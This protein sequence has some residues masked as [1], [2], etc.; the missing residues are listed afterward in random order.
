M[1]KKIIANIF[2]TKVDAI[3]LS[4]FRMAYILVLF[5]E[6]FQ[7]FKFRNIVYDKI[8]FV[9]S[10][11]LYVGFIFLIW[12]V[13]LFLLFIGLFTRTAALIN[14]IFSMIIFS[15]AH[16]FEYHVFYAYVGINLLL[17]FMPIS[18]V[19]S[20]D[21]LI[22]KLKFTNIGR[23]FKVDRKVLEINYLVVVFTVLGLVYFDS[24]FRKLM[25]PMWTDGLG[26]WMPSSLPMVVWTDT[27]FLLNQEFLVKF[28]GYLVIVFESVFIFLFWFK[29]FRW[30]LLLLGIFF[31]LGILVTYPIPWFA[32]TAVVSY[33]LL[34]PQEF[35]LSIS[36]KLKSKTT[37]YKFYYDAECPL[38]NKVV[39][40]IKHFDIFNKINCLTVQAHAASD[41][42]LIGKTEDEL[43]L[44]IHGVDQ[45]GKVFVGFDAYVALLKKMIYTYPIGLL[46]GLPGISYIG[47]KV[48]NYVAGNR[49]TVRC[50]SENC[51]MPVFSE[52]IDEK[53]N[54]LISG[55][56]RLN[57]SKN[58]WKIII[59]LFFAWQLVLISLAPLF[60]EL[61]YKNPL[62]KQLLALKATIGMPIIKATGLGIHPVFMYNIHFEGYN[63][64]FKVVC[65][66][67]QKTVPLLDDN[68]MVTN[69]YAN[70]AFW[71]NYTFRVSSNKLHQDQSAAAPGIAAG[72]GL[73]SRRHQYSLP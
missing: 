53:T 18:R 68:G 64:I 24:V 10:G 23:P 17:L 21:S 2:N 71:V 27:T 36:E 45:A 55:W 25:S 66:K 32:L 22:Q 59:V 30:P 46:I 72:Y 8:P 42:A 1:I 63:H 49:L 70:G 11:E 52:P 37:S 56:N 28:F 69:S 20:L 13:A 73:P 26:M 58:F 3:G 54:F 4:V 39:V 35:W 33:F 7:L 61:K 16:E 47:K 57:V 51:S 65:N 62:G 40:I 5:S 9:D 43:F 41:A 19:F 31:H 6:V 15:S 67:N 34:V 12:F 50:T 60:M 29:K 38:C 44:N 48:Y 14:Y